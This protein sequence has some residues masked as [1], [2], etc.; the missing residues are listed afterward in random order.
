MPTERLRYVPFN[1]GFGQAQC[2]WL[3]EDLEQAKKAGE[4]CLIFSHLPVFAPAASQRNVAFD[5]DEVMRRLGDHSEQVYAFFAGHR[6]SGG[7][8]IDDHG[9]PHITVQSP[10]THGA[11]AAYVIAGN[12]SLSVEGIGAHRSYS[13]G[14]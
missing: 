3:S 6:H 12:R 8:A 10:L 11:C 14:R 9:I 7:S 2:Q 5:A 13:F 4:R 1:G